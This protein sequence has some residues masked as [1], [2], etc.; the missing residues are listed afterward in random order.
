MLEELKDKAAGLMNDEKVKDA[1]DKAKEFINSDKGK[2]TLENVKDK[3]EDFVED[4]TG[5]KGIFGFGKK[6]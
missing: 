6:D 1:V 2:E 4:K 5:G 3:V